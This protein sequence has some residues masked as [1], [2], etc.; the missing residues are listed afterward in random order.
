MVEK[1]LVVEDELALR[2]TITYNL[3]Q[4]G[5]EVL[6]A[7]DGDIAVQIAKEHRPDL[8][9]LD[10]M[11]PKMDGFEVCR[12]LR[13]EMNLPI[14]ILTARSSEIDRVLGLEMG[15]DDYIIKPFSMRE[16]L[17]RV[18]AQLRR[19]KMIREEI[20][21]QSAEEEAI[22]K[23]IL[24]F[25]NLKIDIIRREV[26]RDGKVMALKPKEFE[27]LQY[28]AKH[29]RA[30]LSRD[31]I[32]REVWGW[33]YTGGTRTVDVHIRWLREKIEDNPAKP[34]RIITVHGIG[35]RFEG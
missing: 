13:K 32:L 7:E 12:I 3:Q 16:L 14:L 22:S 5:Y 17:S 23:D 24:T 15:A 11:L 30:A 25:D 21:T 34:S 31:T 2:E 28:L 1:I 26:L 4:Q 6:T 35:Y 9:L 33:E 10:L 18:K 19:M 29:H 20:S 27:L 8:M